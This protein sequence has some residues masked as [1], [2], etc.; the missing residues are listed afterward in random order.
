MHACMYVCMYACM[1]ACM[2][3]CMHACTRECVYACM[4]VCM[5]VCVHLERLG[6]LLA[7][8]SNIANGQI[9]KQ[10][11]VTPPGP[12]PP[13]LPLQQFHLFFK[14]LYQSDINA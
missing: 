3:A 1:Y 5:H 9:M 2:H 6:K 8:L 7:L 12:S 11:R 4:Y 13:L 14:L 10:I